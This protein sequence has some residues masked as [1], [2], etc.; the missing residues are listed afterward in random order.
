VSS[1]RGKLIRT[2]LTDAE[3]Q[4]VKRIAAERDLSASQLVSR[5]IRVYVLK[6]GTQR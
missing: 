4:R 2:M 3:W 5:T 6:K 1:E